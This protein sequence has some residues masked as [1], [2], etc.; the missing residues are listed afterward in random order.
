MKKIYKVAIIGGGAAGLMCATELLRESSSVL[1]NSDKESQQKSGNGF[2]GD[3]GIG[4]IKA[5]SNGDVIIIEKNDRV[6]KKLLSTGNGQGNI[7]NSHISEENYYGDKDFVKK[8]VSVIKETDLTSYFYN[9]GLPLK[10][11]EEG[12]IYPLSKRANA[13]TDLFRAFLSGKAEYVTGTTAKDIRSENGIFVI[14]CGDFKVCAEKVVIAAGGA[15]G[16]QY[17]TDGS[18]YALLEKFGHKKT[19]IFPALVQVK[20]ERDKIKGLKGIKE[21]AEVFAYDK[22]KFLKSQKG[23]VLFTEYGISGTAVFQVSGHLGAAASP[24]VKISFLPD[25]NK[26][27]LKNII[28]DRMKFAPFMKGEDLLNGIV[29]KKVGVA[30]TGGLS[31]ITAESLA[32]ALKNFT[33][34]VTG[35]L[36]FDYAQVTKGGINTDAFNSDTFESN[37]K[38][39]LYAVGE[40]LNIDGDCGG[41]NLTFAFA[42]AISAARDIKMKFSAFKK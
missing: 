12:K 24:W 19:K 18:A 25:I 9:L 40:I 37:L 13:V 36:G 41:Y 31:K 2:I 42:S 33:L 16:K 14:D 1:N 7:T 39:G 23:D 6:G 30:I 17:G 21:E 20:T 11:C 3:A 4:D 38:K 27:K 35:T 8:A 34:K 28:S 10:E 26:E 5:L 32:D 29:N 22:D 15:A